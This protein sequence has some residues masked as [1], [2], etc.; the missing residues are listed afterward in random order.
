MNNLL[1]VVMWKCNG[2]ELNWQRLD[3]EFS[4]CTV[5]SWSQSA[6]QR[7]GSVGYFYASVHPIDGVG[8]II[9][10]F[11]FAQWQHRTEHYNY[12]KTIRD[13]VCLW[14]VCLW[15]L[16]HTHCLCGG[17]LPSVLWHCWLYGRKGIRHAYLSGARCRLAY[18][19]ADATATHCLL[20]Q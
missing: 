3:Y 12:I 19:P 7:I 17:I 6:V 9:S 13:T 2:Q 18:S 4:N 8:G 16:V 1:R 15:M 10:N 5:T 11:Y 14:D 20:L